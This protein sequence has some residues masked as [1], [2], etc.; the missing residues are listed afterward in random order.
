M[1]PFPD[2]Y[3]TGASTMI[4]AVLE[5][6]RFESK[7]TWTGFEHPFLLV[8]IAPRLADPDMALN[9]LE[10]YLLASRSPLAAAALFELRA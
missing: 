3:A 10:R 5:A 8:G 9:N 4:D 6:P 7:I 1:P 2:G